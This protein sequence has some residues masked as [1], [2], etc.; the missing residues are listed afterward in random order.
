[1]VKQDVLNIWSLW[2]NVALIKHSMVGVWSRGKRVVCL[3]QVAV[4]GFIY[5]HL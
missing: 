4:R 1:M 5:T 3:N 2:L